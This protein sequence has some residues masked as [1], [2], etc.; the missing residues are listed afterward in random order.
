MSKLILIC[1]GSGLAGQGACQEDFRCRVELEKLEDLADVV[2]C[3]VIFRE[4]KVVDYEVSVD[5]DADDVAG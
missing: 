4:L 5:A 3:D 1:P 2:G